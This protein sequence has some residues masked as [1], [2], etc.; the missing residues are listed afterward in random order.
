[1]QEHYVHKGAM[2][3][4]NAG[5]FAD[6]NY[7]PASEG[8]GAAYRAGISRFLDKVQLSGVDPQEISDPDVLKG[9]VCY[10]VARRRIGYNDKRITDADA[11]K[12]LACQLGDSYEADL[13]HNSDAGSTDSKF[14]RGVKLGYSAFIEERFRDFSRTPAA[15]KYGLNLEGMAEPERRRYFQLILEL[16]LEL[17]HDE[18]GT[19]P[20]QVYVERALDLYGRKKALVEAQLLEGRHGDALHTLELMVLLLNNYAYNRDENLRSART[21]HDRET[22]IEQCQAAYSRLNPESRLEEIAGLQRDAVWRRDHPEDDLTS[23]IKIH[24]AKEEYEAAAALR[25]ELQRLRD[26]TAR[27][28]QVLEELIS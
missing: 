23:R 18:Q 25:D 15:P 17:S 1:M 11:K 14:L 13:L 27:G 16:R 22:S 20:Q 24:A 6:Y 21:S 26:S 10:L 19:A 12:E 3:P 4:Y 28:G 7:R 5:E 2:N 9:L 8:D